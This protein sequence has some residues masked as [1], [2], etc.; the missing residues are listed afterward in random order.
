[1]DAPEEPEGKTDRFKA[2]TMAI[3]ILMMVALIGM[4]INMANVKD[5]GEGFESM[6]IKIFK[7]DGGI[8]ISF[9]QSGNYT[10]EINSEHLGNKKGIENTTFVDSNHT[11][12]FETGLLYEDITITIKNLRTGYF[13]SHRLEDVV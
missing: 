12:T 9:N 3:I 2:F 6:G 8:E 4:G 1:M 10:I 7:I 13:E 5:T 11:L